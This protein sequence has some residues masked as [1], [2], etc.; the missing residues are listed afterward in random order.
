MLHLLDWKLFLVV[1]KTLEN[2][3]DDF[4]YE[5]R[6]S[7]RR[8]PDTIRGYKAAF[9]LFNKLMPAIT[10]DSLTPFAFSQFCEKLQNRVRVIGNGEIRQGVKDSTIAAYQLKLT[11]FFNW[12]V[13]NGLDAIPR[14]VPKYESVKILRKADIERIRAA[15]EAYSRDLLQLKRDRAMI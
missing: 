7:G 6:F 12:L 13:R 8:R 15:I 14:I 3:F 5:C 11:T 10:A 1:S 2:L 9:D 4:I